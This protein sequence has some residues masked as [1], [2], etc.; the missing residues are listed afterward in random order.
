VAGSTGPLLSRRERQL[1]ATHPGT[2]TINAHRKATE[3]MASVVWTA[4]H[5]NDVV[6]GDVPHAGNHPDTGK[7]ENARLMLAC[8]ESCPDWLP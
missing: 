5:P 6:T 7:I 8:P 1:A 4:L 2:P 3:M